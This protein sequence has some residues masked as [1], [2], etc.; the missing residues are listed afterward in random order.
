M[1][2]I[3]QY[4]V[5]EFICTLMVGELEAGMPVTDAQVEMAGLA[6]VAELPILVLL[7]D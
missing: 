7:G 2:V 4:K 6:A 3:R 1:A 5:L